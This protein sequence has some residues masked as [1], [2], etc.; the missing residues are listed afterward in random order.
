MAAPANQNPLDYAYVTCSDYQCYADY[1]PPFKRALF[2]VDFPI[3]LIDSHVLQVQTYSM[4][5][6]IYIC[7]HR[8]NMTSPL[9]SSLGIVA[10]DLEQ[11]ESA[12]LKTSMYIQNIQA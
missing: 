2:A 7:S 1:A 8:P 9:I 4:S 5:M 10:D 6:C 12:S 3:Y 11:V